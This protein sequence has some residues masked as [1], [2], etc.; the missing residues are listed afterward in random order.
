MLPVLAGAISIADSVCTLREQR[1]ARTWAEVLSQGRAQGLNLSVVVKDA[2][3]GI[4]RGVS[5]VFPKRSS[6]MIVTRS[7]R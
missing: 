3:K 2:A 5:E 6:A 4:A 7:M 1:D